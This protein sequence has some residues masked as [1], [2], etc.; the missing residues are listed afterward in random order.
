MYLLAI[1][2]LVI[3]PHPHYAAHH[4]DPCHA[5]IPRWLVMQG[6]LVDSGWMLPST[7]GSLHVTT[8]KINWHSINGYIAM[9]EIRIKFKI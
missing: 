6:L 3:M 5:G 4:H 8:K 7:I 2:T 1:M 9:R